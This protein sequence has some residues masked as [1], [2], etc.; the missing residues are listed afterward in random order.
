MIQETHSGVV[1]FHAGASSLPGRPW[2]TSSPESDALSVKPESL[3]KIKLH[4]I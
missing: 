3:R 1:L 2:S 4:L